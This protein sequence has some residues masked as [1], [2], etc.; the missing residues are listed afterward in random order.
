MLDTGAWEQWTALLARVEQLS[1]ADKAAILADD[2][3][4]IALSMDRALL[5]IMGQEFEKSVGDRVVDCL[6]KAVEGGPYFPEWYKEMEHRQTPT[7]ITWKE[8]RKIW[9]TPAGGLNPAATK[10]EPAL[11]PEEARSGVCNRGAES[12]TTMQ[13]PRAS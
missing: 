2:H 12:P 9:L 3:A 6:V 4:T 8:L 13:R 7:R 1:E 5:R 11:R 10:A